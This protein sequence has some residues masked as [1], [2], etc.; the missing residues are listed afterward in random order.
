MALHTSSIACS[1][2][3]NP[4]IYSEE[5]TAKKFVRHSSSTAEV[6][7]A[8]DHKQADKMVYVDNANDHSCVFRTEMM[9]DTSSCRFS[10]LMLTATSC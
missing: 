1:L 9:I 2:T 7:D 3:S 10:I 6:Y 5:I 4:S 8:A